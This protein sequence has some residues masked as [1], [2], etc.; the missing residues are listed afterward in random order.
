[1]EQTRI[2]TKDSS[3]IPDGPYCYRLI[4]E[5][6]SSKTPRSSICPYWSYREDKPRQENGFCAYLESGDWEREGVSLLWDQVK[7]CGINA[8]FDE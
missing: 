6:N 5:N 3:V 8:E 4:G 1:M 7:E 2:I